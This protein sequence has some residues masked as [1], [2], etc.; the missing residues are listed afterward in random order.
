MI[1]ILMDISL[2]LTFYP[3][4]FW[5]IG[6]PKRFT[7]V[8]VCLLP[9]FLAQNCFKRWARDKNCTF[10]FVLFFVL[11]FVFSLI[12]VKLEFSRIK[13]K[14]SKIEIQFYDLRNRI[15]FPKEM[16]LSL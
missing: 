15:P 1:F 9:S 14:K 3:T 7:S 11:F 8:F 2:L 6:R 10:F 5:F 13:K 4:K 12:E 16:F